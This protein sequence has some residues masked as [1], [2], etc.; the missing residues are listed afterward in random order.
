M[1]PPRGLEM[2]PKG[3]SNGLVRHLI[4]ALNEATENIPGWDRYAETGKV[5]DI[6]DGKV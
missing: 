1:P 3:M 6:W 2:P 4:E 5:T